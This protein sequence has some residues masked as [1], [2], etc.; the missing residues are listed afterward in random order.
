LRGGIAFT[1]AEYADRKAAGAA[2]TIADSDLRATPQ[3]TLGLAGDSLLTVTADGAAAT[4]P[5]LDCPPSTT[6]TTTRPATSTTT[7]TSAAPATSSNEPADP[8]SAAPGSLA[9]TGTDVAAMTLLGALLLLA[10]AGAIV[11][12]RRKGVHA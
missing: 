9:L 4:A 12:A 10:G 8:A 7:T 1:K 11:L 3:A 5:T 6:T 2:A